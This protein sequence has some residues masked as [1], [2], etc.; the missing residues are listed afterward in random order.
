MDREWFYGAEEARRLKAEAQRWREASSPLAY[1]ER[2]ARE[3]E[4][5]KFLAFLS[6]GYSALKER[7]LPRWEELGLW[8]TLADPTSEEDG[9]VVCGRDRDGASWRY[10]ARMAPDGWKFA[11]EL[12]T[13][14]T[15]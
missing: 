14:E 15:A 7:F 8:Q 1:A 9:Y 10:T 3:K 13:G 4:R 12:M 5:E 2:K 11:E 6:A